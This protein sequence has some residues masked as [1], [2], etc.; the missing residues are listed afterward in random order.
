MEQQNTYIGIVGGD[1]DQE[2]VELVSLLLS[3]S[4]KKK[5]KLRF[6]VNGCIVICTVSKFHMNVMN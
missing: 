3:L 6:K 5:E 4:L 1:S 2:R